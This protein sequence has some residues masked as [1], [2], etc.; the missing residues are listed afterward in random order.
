MI[1]RDRIIKLRRQIR[2]L[3]DPTQAA[4]HAQELKWAATLVTATPEAREKPVAWQSK[5]LGIEPQEWRRHRK[6][7]VPGSTF[8]RILAIL[9]EMSAPDFDDAA[10]DALE[11]MFL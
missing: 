3:P 9:D 4:C 2:S 5:A 8:A 10:F 7:V 1:A 11:T 6:A